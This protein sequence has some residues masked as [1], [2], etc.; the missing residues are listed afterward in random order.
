MYLFHCLEITT[1]GRSTTGT[2]SVAISATVRSTDIIRAFYGYKIIA[3]ARCTISL[4]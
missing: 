3:L 4:I 2:S 1:R